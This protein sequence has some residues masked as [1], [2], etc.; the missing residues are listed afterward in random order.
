MTT[1][2]LVC[3]SVDVANVHI[4]VPSY[5]SV[6]NSEGLGTA[7]RYDA[8]CALSSFALIQKSENCPNT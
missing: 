3:A 5:C 2:I 8:F 4:A 6:F 7:G 1:E